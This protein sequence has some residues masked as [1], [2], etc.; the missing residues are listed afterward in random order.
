MGMSKY[1]L[2][3]IY[4]TKK[5]KRQFDYSQM[6]KYNANGYSKCGKPNKTY[7]LIVGCLF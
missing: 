5:K 4:L 1:N 3:L 7:D 2:S 6:H